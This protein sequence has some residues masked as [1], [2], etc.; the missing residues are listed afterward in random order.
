VRQKI[1]LLSGGAKSKFIPRK[2][3]N[4]AVAQKTPANKF[5][6]THN[7]TQQSRWR[8]QLFVG[9]GNAIA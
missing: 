2:A 8:A 9:C 6:S 1:A 4:K 5:T 3:P 7:A